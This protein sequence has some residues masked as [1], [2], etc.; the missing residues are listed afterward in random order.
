M[1]KMSKILAILALILMLVLG[2]TNI[3]KAATEVDYTGYEVDDDYEEIP[4]D[5]TPATTTTPA[6]ETPKSTETKNV[7]NK[8]TQP[9]PQAGN[10]ETTT[11]IV[12]SSILLVVAGIGYVKYRKYNF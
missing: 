4:S 9:A 1:R 6:P 2:Y 7:S 12:A 8:A 3:S 10:F 5:D 11:I